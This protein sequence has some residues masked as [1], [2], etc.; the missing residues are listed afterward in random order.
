MNLFYWFY[1]DIAKTKSTYKPQ[2]FDKINTAKRWHPKSAQCNIE[3][4][5][6]L[7]WDTYTHTP[8]ERN[9]LWCLKWWCSCV[10]KSEYFI[11]NILNIFPWWLTQ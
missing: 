4:K 7:I 10:R 2:H 11:S 5:V 1:A 9:L 8:K 3:G 6:S